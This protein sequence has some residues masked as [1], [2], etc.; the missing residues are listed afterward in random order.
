MIGEILGKLGFDWKVALANL[1]NFLIIFYLLRNV[2]F[3]KLGKTIKERQEKIQKGL[4]DAKRAEGALVMAESKKEEIL[5]DAQRESR[6]IT[7]NA[8]IEGKKIVAE[9]KSLADEEAQKIKEAA[10]LA[11][12][13]EKT[14]AQKK[15]E[16]EYVAMVLDGVEKILKNG[17]DRSKSEKFAE[18]LLK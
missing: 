6:K 17:I 14:E 7:E 2:V 10:R 13:R 4:D 12:E 3:K 11:S 1:V 9:A 16:K 15:L 18:G 8:D 5:K